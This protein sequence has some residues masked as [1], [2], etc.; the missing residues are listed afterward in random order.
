[1]RTRRQRVE[2]YCTAIIVP[3]YRFP[4]AG[5][6]ESLCIMAGCSVSHMMSRDIHELPLMSSVSSRWPLNPHISLVLL[7]IPDSRQVQYGTDV[8]P[9]APAQRNVLLLFG[10]P[11]FCRQS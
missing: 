6:Q 8:S 5:G 1:M 2:A 3:L 11:K 9:S 7:A 4:G 10:A